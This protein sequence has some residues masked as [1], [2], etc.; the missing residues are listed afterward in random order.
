MINSLSQEARDAFGT[1]DYQRSLD[2]F[3]QAVQADPSDI[4][5]SY[6][7]VMVGFHVNPVKGFEEIN[8][9]GQL[10]DDY[11]KLFMT[12]DTSPEAQGVLI[13]EILAYTA[14]LIVRLSETAS[15]SF[16]KG[17]INGDTL[18]TLLYLLTNFASKRYSV[19]MTQQRDLPDIVGGIHILEEAM[20]IVLQT[21]SNARSYGVSISAEDN[22]SFSNM[23]KML[24]SQNMSRGSALSSI[25][26][27]VRNQQNE[28]ISINNSSDFIQLY[29][30]Y[31][32]K[33]DNYL[34]H[35]LHHIDDME[36]LGVSI[37]EIISAS[38]DDGN[39]S[40][41]DKNAA[42]EGIIA[43]YNLFIL[44]IRDT[45]TR[46]YCERDGRV[47][48]DKVLTL[49]SMASNIAVNA[50]GV[51]NDI[52]PLLERYPRLSNSLDQLCADVDSLIAFA[53]GDMT[54]TSGKRVSAPLNIHNLLVKTSNM[55]LSQ[56]HLFN[57]SASASGGLENAVELSIDDIFPSS[58]IDLK[59]EKEERIRKMW[60]DAERERQELL[61]KL[62]NW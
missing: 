33:I 20:K 32:A 58:S 44:K 16:N 17:E 60:E 28:S 36:D 39:T 2:L 19:A 13:N 61:D 31:L 56:W 18:I 12:E 51:I 7:L 24:E 57:P 48:D 50:C 45:S 11:M 8:N 47:D 25:A 34:K 26:G 46:R 53:Y 37:K 30:D 42:F 38:Q 55:L 14:S 54:T 5:A 3:N 6:L 21:V 15:D 22:D 9:I 40:F 23:A 35:P 41:K 59:K 62:S 4:R 27:N 43:G 29:R 10:T 49:R 1:G 52:L